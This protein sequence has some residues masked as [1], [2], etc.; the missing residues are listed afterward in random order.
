MFKCFIRVTAQWAGSR[1][2]FYINCIVFPFQ[3]VNKIWIL[4]PSHTVF[5]VFENIHFLGVTTLFI[6]HNFLYSNLGSKFVTENSNNLKSISLLYMA[7]VHSLIPSPGMYG[8]HDVPAPSSR[9]RH[10]HKQ[11]GN[12]VDTVARRQLIAV[13]VL[14]S[15]FMVG[16]AI[17]K[18]LDKI[19]VF[20]CLAMQ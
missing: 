9:L 1:F 7:Y 17:G 10:C 15:M 16:E 12:L 13:V 20:M 6:F 14:C 3:C 2:F 18:L 8:S 5:S 11:H 19:N 4:G